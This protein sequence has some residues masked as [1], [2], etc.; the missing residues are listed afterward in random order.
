MLGD[1]TTPEDVERERRSVTM[2]PAGAPVYDRDDALISSPPWPRRWPLLGLD[3]DDRGGDCVRAG[4][5][6]PMASRMSLPPGKD[7]PRPRVAGLPLSGS[8]TV[9]VRGA[10]SPGAGIGLGAAENPPY[11]ILRAEK[12]A[13][14]DATEGLLGD[15]KKLG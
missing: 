4:L 3:L 12:A 7:R 14:T 9:T 2:L 1:I 6:V 5:S 15:V 8:V 10:G 11:V 13:D